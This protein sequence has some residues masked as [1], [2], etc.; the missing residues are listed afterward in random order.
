MA[1]KK[2]DS[3]LFRRRHIQWTI[4]KE[5]TNPYPS[6]LNRIKNGITPETQRVEKRLQEMLDMKM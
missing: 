3:S 6:V 2:I 5:N 1:L 4:T